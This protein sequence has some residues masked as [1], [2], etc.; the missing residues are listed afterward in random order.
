[1]TTEYRVK[2]IQQGNSQTLP[3]PPELNLNTTDVIIRQENGK[4]IIEPYQ[5]KSLLQV[6]STLEPIDE[7]FPD[8]DAGLLP[9]DDIE[10]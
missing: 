4:L 2:L 5:K 1:M 8:I 6:F 9:L 7:E 10:L 3:I